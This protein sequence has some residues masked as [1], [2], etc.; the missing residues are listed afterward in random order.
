MVRKLKTPGAELGQIHG[1]KARC[2]GG[3]RLK[4]GRQPPLSAG[5]CRPLRTGKLIK[6]EEQTAS[7]QQGQGREEDQLTLETVLA[8]V[9]AMGRH[10]VP[11]EKAQP[12]HHN[13]QADHKVH[14]RVPHIPCQ[15]GEGPC[16][17]HQVK[18]RVAEGGDRVKNT[19][20]NALPQPKLG[21]EPQRQQQ[22]L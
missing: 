14:Q 13:E 15:G 1:V 9:P 8:H 16:L 12:P 21:T 7:H 17:P 18:A 4:Q 2:P 20:P 22:G 11:S 5:Q 3:D 6:P 19:I 10:I